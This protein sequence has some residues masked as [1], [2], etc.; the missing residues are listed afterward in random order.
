VV[1]LRVALGR[2]T[3]TEPTRLGATTLIDRT[4][5]CRERR[6]LAQVVI[7]VTLSHLSDR[8]KRFVP[9]VNDGAE[10]FD[11]DIADVGIGIVA[12]GDERTPKRGLTRAALSLL[13]VLAAKRVE[14]ATSYARVRVVEYR[15]KVAQSGVIEQSIDHIDAAD[16]DPHVGVAESGS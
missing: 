1:A 12:R 14:R 7:R 8:G 5:W 9:I 3:A 2:R 15:K 4:A 10:S 13:A 6:L 11:C 16:D